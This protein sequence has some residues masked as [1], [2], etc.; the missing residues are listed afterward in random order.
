MPR[1]T[2]KP[3][4]WSLGLSSRCADG[5]GLDGRGR[6]GRPPRAAHQP[7]SGPAQSRHKRKLRSRAERKRSPAARQSLPTG[8][9]PG[10]A[11]LT[12]RA[13]VFAGR[14]A[15]H[16]VRTCPR[17]H[18]TPAPR[19]AAGGGARS[20]SE[21][22]AGLLAVVL[23]DPGGHVEGPRVGQEE[24]AED[25][26]RVRVGGERPGLRGEGG[27]G[28]RARVARVIFHPAVVCAESERSCTRQADGVAGCF[29]EK[30]MR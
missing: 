28:R 1:R 29:R 2:P 14:G 3:D 24:R 21:A 10:F 4:R 22:A 8:R 20:P 25:V 23:L 30:G 16:R 15:G 27:A 17:F 13:A 5:W 18:K 7:R 12:A 9:R 6:G 26:E 11:H 19:S